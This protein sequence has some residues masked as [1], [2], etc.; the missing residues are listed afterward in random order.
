MPLAK[1]KNLRFNSIEFAKLISKFSKTQV[2][3]I[4]NFEEIEKYFKKNLT[5]DEIIIGMGAGLISKHM[6]E[7]KIAL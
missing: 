1:K 7:L 2:I 3:V 6:R 5:S 4:K